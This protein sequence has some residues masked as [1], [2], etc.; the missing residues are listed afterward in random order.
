MSA[1][2]VCGGLA[3]V[4]AVPGASGQSAVGARWQTLPLKLRSYPPF[5]EP[6]SAS[7]RTWFLVHREGAKTLLLSARLSGHTF[8]SFVKSTLP[9]TG[10]WTLLGSS[11]VYNPPSGDNRARIAPLLSGGR[12]G[13]AQHLPGDPEGKV[14]VLPTFKG[15]A[16]V[17]A[18][19]RIAGRTIW[20]LTGGE[21]DSFNGKSSIAVCCTAAGAPVDLTHLLTNRRWAATDL[22]LGTDAR[23]RLFAAWGDSKNNPSRDP[24]M[25]AHLL[26]LDPSTLAVRSAKTL[27]TASGSSYVTRAGA[28]FSLV[29]ACAKTCRLVVW[30]LSGTYTWGPGERAPTKIASRLKG[31]LSAGWSAGRIAVSYYVTARSGYVGSIVAARGDRRGAHLQARSS[32]VPPVRL[33]SRSRPFSQSGP[34]Q[35]LLTPRGA[36]VVEGYDTYSGAARALVAFL[37]LAR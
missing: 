12:L 29:L 31:I 22:H 3:A 26:E 4:P 15:G 33:G 16:T 17:R 37:P 24:K 27:P 1:A 25:I 34:P 2:L 18:A 6:F 5:T 9:E 8:R 20:F 30:P 35:A 11:F 23:G 13:A 19:T 36:I 10:P 7:G 14:L 28:G 21:A 32:V